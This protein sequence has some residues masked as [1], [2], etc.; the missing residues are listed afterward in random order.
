MSVPAS[1]CWTWGTICYPMR[2]AS[3]AP[4]HLTPQ[5]ALLLTFRG[6]WGDRAGPH[7]LRTHSA[8]KSLQQLPALVNLNL[9]GN[10]VCETAGYPDV[11]RPRPRA[12][13]ATDAPWRCTTHATQRVHNRAPRRLGW[14]AQ[15]R[16]LIPSL[17]ILDGQRFDLAFLRRKS[18]K[19][20][21][22][23]DRVADPVAQGPTPT[24]LHA[25][26]QRREVADSATA[27]SDPPRQKRQRLAGDTPVST[28]E[29]TQPDLGGPTT[30]PPRHQSTGVVAIVEA[31]PR[32]VAAITK[33]PHARTK[34][35]QAAP[36]S[37]SD[38]W[39]SWEAPDANIGSGRIASAWQ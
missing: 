7:G 20:T 10:P 24:T 39:A 32:A 11:V 13:G 22:A 9:K 30:K 38:V 16:E 2:G 34:T 18:R 4:K 5:H 26:K 25:G 6:R 19:Q 21:D 14:A 1:S 17:R 15:I 28:P 3:G 8:L 27:P 36:T 29:I 37:A 33:K 31:R 12:S 23:H 35:R